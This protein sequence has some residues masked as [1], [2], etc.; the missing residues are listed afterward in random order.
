MTKIDTGEKVNIAVLNVKLSTIQADVKEIKENMKSFD[1]R[2]A[3]REQLAE[4]AKQ[5]ELRLIRLEEA[6]NLWK[7]LSPT[8]A[9]IL[10]SVVTF[11]LIQYLIGVK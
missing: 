11:L 5:T 4:T 2:Y 10:G 8:L 3:T 7:F 1:S 9:A 6:S